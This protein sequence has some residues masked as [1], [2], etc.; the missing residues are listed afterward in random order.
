[1]RIRQ[2]CLLLV[3]VS[4]LVGS[5]CRHRHGC[6][7]QS[8]CCTPCCTCCDSCCGYPPGEVLGPPIT[9]PIA[10][11]AVSVGPPPLANPPV[12]MA[13]ATR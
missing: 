6:C 11:P 1:M 8:Y 10:S 7:R 5:G 12:P 4:L 3:L 9:G 2:L 13:P